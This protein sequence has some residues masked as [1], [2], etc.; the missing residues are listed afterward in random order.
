MPD[1]LIGLIDTPVSA[2]PAEIRGVHVTAALASIDGKLD[3][4]IALKDSCLNTIELDVKDE[5][6]EVAFHSLA[7]S[8]ARQIGAAKR[9][10]DPKKVAAQVDKKGMYL[11]G[12]VVCFE[13][14][15]L[16]EKRPDYAIR[17]TGG[18]VWV[19]HG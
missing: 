3:E 2:G 15:I 1:T 18:G 13:D 12:R 4:Y 19:N 7:P 16:A 10:Y 6:G 11:I 9:Y 8:L 5:N 17:T 14:P